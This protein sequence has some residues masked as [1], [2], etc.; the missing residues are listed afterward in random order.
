MITEYWMPHKHCVLND[1]KIITLDAIGNGLVAVT[2]F[3]IP[4]ILI[5]FVLKVWNYLPERLRDLLI[6]AG[7]FIA[8]CGAAHVM[9][10]WNWWHTDYQ[11]SALL[12]FFTGLV[13][14]SFAIRLWGY[15]MD[16][17]RGVVSWLKKHPKTLA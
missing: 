3:L 15:T 10:I 6:H 14:L 4:L 7:A 9:K 8:L 1:Y 5:A 12:T 11:V 13:S 2:Y 17:E 16:I